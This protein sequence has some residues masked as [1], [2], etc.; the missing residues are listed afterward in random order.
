MRSAPGGGP[1]FSALARARGRHGSIREEL[2]A[3]ATK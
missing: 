2:A 1:I 3:V